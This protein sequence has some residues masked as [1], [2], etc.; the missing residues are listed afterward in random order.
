MKPL[1]KKQKETVPSKEETNEGISVTLRQSTLLRR[2]IAE[3]ERRL[4]EL[5]RIKKPLKPNEKAPSMEVFLKEVAETEALNL[6]SLNE[7]QAYE[8]ESKRQ[9]LQTRAKNRMESVTLRSKRV[10]DE[11]RTFLELA[12]LKKIPNWLKPKHKPSEIARQKCVITGLPAKYRDPVTQFPYATIEAFQEI[13]AH[14]KTKTE[15]L[16][17]PCPKLDKD[18]V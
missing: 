7:L 9:A 11:E 5:N 13:R 6:A 2:T 16:Q 3:E 17:E 15:K 8:A 1:V 10:G 14:L 18:V 12:H 4:I